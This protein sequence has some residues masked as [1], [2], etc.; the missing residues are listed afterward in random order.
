MED[1]VEE[2]EDMSSKSMVA[3]LVTLYFV[4]TFSVICDVVFFIFA[5]Q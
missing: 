2:G 3:I 5:A 4:C 1:F